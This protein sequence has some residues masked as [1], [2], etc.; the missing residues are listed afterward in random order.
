MHMPRWCFDAGELG[1]GD[2]N[3]HPRVG[4]PPGAF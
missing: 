2:V 4:S 3:P 1:I